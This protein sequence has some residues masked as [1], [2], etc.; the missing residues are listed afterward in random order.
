MSRVWAWIA[1]RKRWIG[2][3][4]AYTILHLLTFFLPQAPTYPKDSPAFTRWLAGMR[5]SF[6][7]RAGMWAEIGLFTLRSSLLLRLTLG[8]IGILVAVQ[9]AHLWEH[10]HEI[11]KGARF[12]VLA[13]SLSGVILLGGWFAH[14]RWGWVESGVIAWPDQPVAVR[15]RQLGSIQA[16]GTLPIWTRH[17]GL[18]LVPEGERTGLIIRAFNSD[19]DTLSLLSSVRDDPKAVMRSVLTD[20]SPETFFAVPSAGMVFRLSEWED[21]VRVQAYRSASGELLAEVPLAT[22]TPLAIEDVTL[23]VQTQPLSRYRAVYNP[24]AVFEVLGALGVIVSLV[25][26]FVQQADMEADEVPVS[27]G[28]SETEETAA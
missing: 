9:L 25:I 24:G 23:K 12:R 1:D 2:A 16:R 10:R 18:Y 7:D 20:P 8:Y 4:V 11:T 26:G 14:I 15:D 22:E 6:G 27:P 17:Y 13:L 19:G 21:R 3:I 28:A 5:P